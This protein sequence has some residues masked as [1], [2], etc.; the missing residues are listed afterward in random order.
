MFGIGLRKLAGKGDGVVLLEW[1]DGTVT[2]ETLSWNSEVDAWEI[3]RLDKRI[4]PRGKGGDPKRL[5]GADV[6]YAYADVPAPVST[7]T[8]ILGRALNEEQTVETDANGQP[9]EPVASDEPGEDVADPSDPGAVAD[10]G[11]AVKFSSNNPAVNET[12]N[13]PVKG[14]TWDAIEI[15]LRDAVE[16]DP[17]PADESDARK[18]AEWAELSARDQGKMLRYLAYGF[19]AAAGFVVLLMVVIWLL[20][21]IGDGSTGIQLTLA[22]LGVV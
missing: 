11:Q 9:T 12:P 21:Q 4:F 18:A 20:G 8:A 17:Y 14:L 13:Y 15:S 3:P 5:M 1:Q 16:Y 10:G 19:G 7:E 2:P 22:G 6:V